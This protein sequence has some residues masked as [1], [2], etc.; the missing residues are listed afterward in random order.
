MARVYIV[1]KGHESPKYGKG[2]RT[3]KLDIY[4]RVC[5]GLSLVV[6]METGYIAWMMLN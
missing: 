6:L 5:I 3:T 1:P 2:K 4:K